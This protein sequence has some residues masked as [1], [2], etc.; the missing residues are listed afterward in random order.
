MILSDIE[1][2]VSKLAFNPITGC[3][4][5]MGCIS[6]GGQRKHMKSQI[7]YGSFWYRG[8]TVRAHLWAAEHIHGIDRSNGEHIDHACRYSLCVHH[9]RPCTPTQNALW[10]N[11][12]K[13]DFDWDG[14]PFFVKPDWLWG[15]DVPI[16]LSRRELG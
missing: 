8:R 6:Y 1:R 4:I 11:L 3:V 2:F 13:P 7:P 12:P 5:W 14:P 16:I 15:F 9:L 10:S